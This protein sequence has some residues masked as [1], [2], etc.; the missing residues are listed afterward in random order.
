MRYFHKLIP[1]LFVLL[2]IVYVGLGCAG[3]QD[4]A[5]GAEPEFPDFV[6]NSALALQAY[7]L[8]VKEKDVLA[9]IPCYCDCGR[10]SQHTS[11]KDCFYKSDGTFNDHASNCDVCEQ[12]I[13]DL[14]A[15]REQGKDLRQI[16]MMIDEKYR[17][18]GE[19]TNTPPID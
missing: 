16:R 5:V 12:E 9:R 4:A 2:A 14:S 3:S 17:D 7:R 13:I 18:W 15:W 1:A 6:Y 11:L 10:A 8:A 19:P